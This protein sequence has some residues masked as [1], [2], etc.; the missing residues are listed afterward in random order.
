MLLQHSKSSAFLPAVPCVARPI[1]LK[2]ICAVPRRR[3]PTSPTCA[4]EKL[5]VVELSEVLRGSGE[6]ELRSFSERVRVDR[7]RS[8]VTTYLLYCSVEG[9]DETVRMVE[10]SGI[11]EGDALVV[12]EGIQIYQRGYQTPDPYWMKIVGKD[13]NAKPV[14]WAMDTFFKEEVRGKGGGGE[15]EVVFERR[16][17]KRKGEGEVEGGG[18]REGLCEKIRN[19]LEEMGIRARVR[20]RGKDVVVM[21][22]AGSVVDAVG[23]CQTMLRIGEENTFVFGSDGLVDRCVR[24]KGNMGICGERSAEKWDGFGD[25]IFVSQEKGMNALLDGLVYYAIF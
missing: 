9:Y 25:R 4:A 15:Y 7:E 12:L 6:R 1:A 20:E 21:A 23:F 5:L 17:K 16:G 11:V 10:K 19:K 2:S 18:E 22:A 13:W 3:R 8:K 14:Q 24:G